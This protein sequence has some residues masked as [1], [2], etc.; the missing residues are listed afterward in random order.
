MLSEFIGQGLN[1]IAVCTDTGEM[2]DMTLDYG[3]P[4]ELQLSPGLM[5]SI[6]QWP[7]PQ[8][9]R[10]PFSGGLIDYMRPVGPGVYVGCGWKRGP[11]SKRGKRFLYFLLVRLQT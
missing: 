3:S 5:P 7:S 4:E 11:G 6:R 10:W 2:A 8:V 1:P 9:P